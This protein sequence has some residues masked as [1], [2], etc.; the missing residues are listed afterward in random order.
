MLGIEWASLGSISTEFRCILTVDRWYP[1]ASTP[2]LSRLVTKLTSHPPSTRLVHPHFPRS[3]A[4]M[5]TKSSGPEKR[6]LSPRKEL[7]LCAHSL[8]CVA[9]S[10][11]GEYYPSFYYSNDGIWNNTELEYETA[12]LGNRSVDWIRN[13]TADR[14]PWFLYIA[15]HAPHGL[16][17]PAPWYTKLTINATAPRSP[18]WNYSATDHHWLIAQQPALTTAEAAT[19]DSKFRKR[20]QCLRAADDTIA[21]LLKEVNTLADQSTFIFASSDN[22]YHF[23]ELRLGEGKWNVYDTDVRLPMR[24]AGPGIAQ[25]ITLGMVGSHVDLAPTWLELAGLSIPDEMDGRSLVGGLIGSTTESTG[26]EVRKEP[27]ERD[28]LPVG[29]ALIEYHSLGMVGA[30]GRLGDAWNNTYRAL[31]IIDRRPYGL[32]NVLYVEFGDYSFSTV[33]FHEFF[34]LETD[35]W[36]LHSTFNALSSA[37]KSAWATRLARAYACHGSSCRDHNALLRVE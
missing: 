30:P 19:F 8:T 32:G 9:L 14:V 6:G 24:V 1:M 15:P 7:M 36:Q 35:P 12:F 27:G 17:L 23:G 13:A 34:D 4:P 33:Q 2:S 25:G 16:A 31:R 22:G 21:A 28:P 3:T 18:S 29:L 20:W 11:I 26:G 5:K 37:N 10:R